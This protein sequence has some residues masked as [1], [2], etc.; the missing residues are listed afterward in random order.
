V[1][2]KQQ[3]HADAALQMRL[4]YRSNGRRSRMQLAI[5]QKRRGSGCTADVHSARLSS[6]R[7]RSLVFTC[8]ALKQLRRPAKIRYDA[9]APGWQQP[10]A[11]K[12]A[13]LSE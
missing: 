2:Q 7:R 10:A 3:Q 9:G 11:W 4:R 5:T 8:P 6:R 12:Q 1:Q 13:S